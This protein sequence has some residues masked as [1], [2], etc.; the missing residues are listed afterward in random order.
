MKARNL[1]EPIAV[2]A[3]APQPVVRC[4]VADREALI[5]RRLREYLSRRSVKAVSRH[6]AVET[7]PKAAPAIRLV[8]DRSPP[9]PVQ[10]MPEPTGTF[11]PEP[12]AWRREPAWVVEAMAA[13]AER[14]R[15]ERAD[16]QER[17]RTKMETSVR[18]LN[19]NTIAAAYAVAMEA[20][21]ATD[22]DFERVTGKGTY[23]RDVESVERRRAVWRHMNDAGVSYS[24]LARIFGVQHSVIMDCRNPVRGWSK[25]TQAG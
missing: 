18:V 22:D 19:V 8:L 25:M 16:D 3:P 24:D 13:E 6:P 11:P 1:L 14:V 5:R 23:S 2:P 21:G 10:A 9:E 7:V 4:S 20:A 12:K 15:Q 17:Q